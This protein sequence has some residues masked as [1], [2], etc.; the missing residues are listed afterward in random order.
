LFANLFNSGI[1]FNPL[2]KQSSLFY[3]QRAHVNFSKLFI[4][5]K[6]YAMLKLSG[7][8]LLLLVLLS[9]CS[10]NPRKTMELIEEGR[11]LSNRADYKGAVE[12]YSRAIKYDDQSYEAYFLRG[13][14]FFNLRNYKAA[15]EDYLKA[16]EIKPDYADAWFNLGQIMDYEQDREMACYYYKKA[17][18][19]KKPN[20][21]DYLRNCP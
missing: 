8:S 19:Y 7:F 9:A 17:A 10:P 6:N 2:I 14:S 12:A 13:A 4:F 18:E 20:I 16:V 11:K 1:N 21:G 3:V 5:A 15:V